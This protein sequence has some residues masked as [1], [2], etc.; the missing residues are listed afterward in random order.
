MAGWAQ[1]PCPPTPLP[2]HPRGSQ[3]TGHTLVTSPNLGPSA[4]CPEPP[5]TPRS[6][7]TPV[8]SLLSNK[9]QREGVGRGCSRGGGRA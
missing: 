1:G 8:N 7:P 5:S 9:E 3:E 4:L 2:I 6:P